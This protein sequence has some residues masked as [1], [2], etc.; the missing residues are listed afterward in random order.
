MKTLSFASAAELRAWLAKNNGQSNGILLRIYKKASG[1]ASVSYAEALDQALCY[2]WIDGQK[3][4]ADEQSW[5]QTFTPRR[6]KSGWS[7]KNTEHAERLIKSG[8]MTAAG[9]EEIGGRKSGRPLASRLRLVR[10]RVDPGRFHQAD[11]GEQEGEVVF[12]NAQPDQS[13]FHSLPP[14]DRQETRDAPKADAGH[15]RNVGARREISLR[16]AWSARR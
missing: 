12:R 6:P 8:D 10:Q 15:H 1:V 14:A 5:L 4:P 9:L 7:K 3:L 2:G 13:L 16:D 11:R